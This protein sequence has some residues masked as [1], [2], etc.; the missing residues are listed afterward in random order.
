MNNEFNQAGAD[1]RP[2]LSAPAPSAEDSSRPDGQ[3]FPYSFPVM[4]ANADIG[5]E[6]Q[7]GPNVCSEIFL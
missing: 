5:K 4:E 3:Y 7:P 6:F 2:R 1:Q